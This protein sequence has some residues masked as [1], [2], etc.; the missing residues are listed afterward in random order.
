MPSPKPKRKKAPLRLPPLPWSQN[1]NKLIWKLI[2]HLN[3]PGMGVI[4]GHNEGEVCHN[5]HLLLSPN[6]RLGIE[7]HR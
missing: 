4:I 2:G 1:N 7:Y 3:E 5:A 6:L